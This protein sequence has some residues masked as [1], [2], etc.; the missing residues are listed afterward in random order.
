MWSRQ[1]RRGWMIQS[2]GRGVWSRSR[3]PSI[4]FCCL[5]CISHPS[6]SFPSSFSSHSLRPRLCFSAFIPLSFPCPS[7]PLLSARAIS[8]HLPLYPPLEALYLSIHFSSSSLLHTLSLSLLLEP[9]IFDGI[10]SSPTR[11]PNLISLAVDC[12]T[13]VSSESAD[14]LSRIRTIAT[15]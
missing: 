9:P 15:S 13:L 5:K 8:T 10:P 1:L 7:F 2:C 12:L 11:S 14:L 3:K 6:V 4:M